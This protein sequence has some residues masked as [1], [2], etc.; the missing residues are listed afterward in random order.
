MEIKILGTGCA[1]CKEL[2]N[3][4]REV[5]RELGLHAEVVKEDDIT[6]IMEY[7]ILRTPGLVVDGSVLVSGRLP[8]KE[9]LKSLFIKS[10]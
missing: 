10:S 8:S 4:T 6:R 3:I 9:E 7:G 1:R 5:V 2:E